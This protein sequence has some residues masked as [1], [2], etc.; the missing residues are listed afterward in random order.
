MDDMTGTLSAAE[1]RLRFDAKTLD[2]LADNIEKIIDDLIKRRDALRR[3]AAL[4]ERCANDLGE[5]WE[6]L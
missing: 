5:V 1:A 4:I 3:D 2:S 6:E